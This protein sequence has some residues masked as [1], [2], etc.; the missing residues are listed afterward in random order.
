M[1][2]TNEIFFSFIY[3][4]FHTKLDRAEQFKQMKISW[5][6]VLVA[7]L[8]LVILGGSASP[9]DNGN[10]AWA[11][12]PCNNNNNNKRGIVVGSNDTV[13]PLVG[14]WATTSSCNPT[15]TQTSPTTTST[16]TKATWEAPSPTPEPIKCTP[17]NTNLWS[18]S[19]YLY[20]K[21]S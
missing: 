4:S 12:T 20:R 8:P 1:A 17:A 18:W 13:V 9:T 3:Y 21:K 14:N 19:D 11:Q 15:P 2:E 10:N 7:I 16:G 6:L 5:Y